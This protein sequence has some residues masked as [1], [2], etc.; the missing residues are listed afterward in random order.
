[1]IT[2][3]C[4]LDTCLPCY[5][6]G[7]PDVVLAVSVWHG[8][9]YADLKDG[10]DDESNASDHGIDDWEGFERALNKLFSNINDMEAPWDIGLTLE[11]NVGN[12]TEGDESDTE[13]CVAY[14]SLSQQDP[15]DTEDDTEDDTNTLAS[16]KLKNAK[17]YKDLKQLLREDDIAYDPWGTVS[18]FHFVL[19]GETEDRGITPDDWQFEQSIFGR[20]E[21]DKEHIAYE[22]LC[23]AADETLLKFGNL[24]Q[25]YGRALKHASR[26]Y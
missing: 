12:D 2:E 4:Y 15:N 10:I 7:S 26:D 22:Y 17:D 25:R 20:P 18:I 16:N 24:L 6:Q 1:M 11:E 3:I 19:A 8:M 13:K 5:F 21:E 23:D 9:T 14:F